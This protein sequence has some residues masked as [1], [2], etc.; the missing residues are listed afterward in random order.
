[1]M[2]GQ[3]QRPADPLLEQDDRHAE[4]GKKQGATDGQRT[5][6]VNNAE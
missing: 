1:M 3:L 4:R 5:D 2:A 6:E